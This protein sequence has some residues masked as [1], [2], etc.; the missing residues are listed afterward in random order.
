MACLPVL[1]ALLL[2]PQ[3]KVYVLCLYPVN[4]T[5]ES[6]VDRHLRRIAEKP[7]GF[8][9]ISLVSSHVGRTRIH[10]DNREVIATHLVQY[11]SRDFPNTHSMTASEVD[12]IV[13]QLVA[14]S[15]RDNPAGLLLDPCKVSR[16]LATPKYNRRKPA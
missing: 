9:N 15:G 4:V 2:R 6:F 1:H 13:L 5:V 14:R 3:T 10:M 7:V 16:L 8:G 12:Y 11:L